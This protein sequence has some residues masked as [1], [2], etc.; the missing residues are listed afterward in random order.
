MPNVN[1]LLQYANC[2][3]VEVPPNILL[4]LLTLSF[5]NKDTNSCVYPN[6]TNPEYRVFIHVWFTQI[7]ME[8]YLKGRVILL[9]L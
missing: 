9:Y 5:R 4:V 1:E 3:S 7:E 8:N 6:F 2:L